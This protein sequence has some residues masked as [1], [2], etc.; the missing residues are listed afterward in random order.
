MD[1]LHP[2]VRSQINR[3]LRAWGLILL[4]GAIEFFLALLPV[5]HTYRPL[6]MLPGLAMIAGVALFF[7]EVNR[8]P[9]IVRAFAVAALF[10]LFVLLALGSCDPFTRTEYKVAPIVASG[11]PAQP[12]GGNHGQESPRAIIEQ[13]Q[14]RGLQV[15]R[16]AQAF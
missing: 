9:A 15:F 11:A 14:A 4:L 2:H 6:I 8:G 5:A 16:P 10:W 13:P 7:M 1:A 12:F 3:L